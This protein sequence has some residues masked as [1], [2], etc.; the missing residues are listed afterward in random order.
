[1][2]IRHRGWRSRLAAAISAGLAAIGVLALGKGAATGSSA[3]AAAGSNGSAFATAAPEQQPY[4]PLT[5]PARLVTGFGGAA[6][7]DGQGR[8]RAHRALAAEPDGG[9]VQLPSPA[10]AAAALPPAAPD[11]TGP[12]PALAVWRSLLEDRWQDRLSALTQL[13]LA[14]HDE[15]GRSGGGHTPDGKGQEQ[16]L[17]RLMRE[18]TAARRGLCDTE[19]A[20][21]RVSNGTFGRC[22]QCSVL[23]P[24]SEL[25]AEPETRYCPECV[26]AASLVT[27]AGHEAVTR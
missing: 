3:L 19:E 2:T 9:Q 20:L 16:Q 17:Q 18:A 23:I 7:Y 25:M 26:K 6:A 5:A 22:E 27:G 12:R 15:A 21:A 1:M 11:G 10:R 8:R 4:V 24:I 14:Y 13:S